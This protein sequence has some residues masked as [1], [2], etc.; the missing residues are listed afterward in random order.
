M[1]C[2][3]TESTECDAVAW[4]LSERADVRVTY[5]P[6]CLPKPREIGGIQE[7]AEDSVAQVGKE[8]CI[9]PCFVSFPEK[10]QKELIL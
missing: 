1:S 3:W 2:H 5:Q 6:S 8:F 9:E 10:L 7:L 4:L